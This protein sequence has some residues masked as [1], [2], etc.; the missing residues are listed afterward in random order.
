MPESVTTPDIHEL[1]LAEGTLHLDSP[2]T[3]DDV[4]AAVARA[5]AA[6]TQAYRVAY[7]HAHGDDEDE[8]VD[9]LDMAVTVLLGI[10]NDLK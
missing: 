1:L 8:T 9:N 7:D 10:A 6:A 2:Q 4:S 5:V 3:R